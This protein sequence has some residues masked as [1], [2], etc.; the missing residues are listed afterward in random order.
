MRQPFRPQRSIEYLSRRN[1][2]RLLQLQPRWAWLLHL[3]LQWTKQITYNK[4]KS[5][6]LCRWLSIIWGLAIYNVTC[7]IDL[8]SSILYDLRLFLCYSSS[9]SCSDLLWGHLLGL[10][11]S[12]LNSIH[13]HLRISPDFLVLFSYLYCYYSVLI[14]KLAVP[15]FVLVLSKT[16]YFKS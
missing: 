1:I 8:S 10:V 7:S 3:W 6:V 11:L 15:K 4:N 9:P 2:S 5:Q 13:A 12:V 16:S 14:S